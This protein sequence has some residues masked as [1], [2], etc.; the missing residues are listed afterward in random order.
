MNA[1]S[2]LRGT[3]ARESRSFAVAFLLLLA[4]LFLPAFSMPHDVH[5]Y[6]V[7]IDISQSMNVE[8][9]EQ[10]GTPVSR[11]E[12]CPPG[13]AT[14]AAGSALRLARRVGGLH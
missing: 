10:D 9:Y 11:L 4:A 3:F 1:R 5:T 14:R 12:F 13:G 6:L 7:F 8:D 2:M